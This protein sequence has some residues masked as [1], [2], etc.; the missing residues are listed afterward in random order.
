MD[1]MNAL[2]RA[3][4]WLRRGISRN[5]IITVGVVLVLALLSWLVEETVGW[6]DWLTPNPRHSVRGIF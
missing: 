3:S 6:P 5:F 1:F 2:V 4:L